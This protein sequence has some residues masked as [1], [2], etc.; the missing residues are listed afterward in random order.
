[1]YKLVR[2]IGSL[3]L[4]I[5]VGFTCKGK[6]NIPKDGSAII[7]SNHI[8]LFDPLSIGICTRR[9]IIFLAKKEL[10]SSK[11]SKWFFGSCHAIP[12]G[13][14][15]NDAYSLK[16]SLAVIKGNGLLGIFPEGTRERDAKAMQFKAGVGMLATKSQVPVIPVYISGSYKLNGKLKVIIGKAIDLKEYYGRKLTSQEYS[17]ISNEIVA[18][19]IFELKECI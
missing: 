10:F 2:A 13:R 14:D 18:K 15:G 8:H 9:V 6:D 16:K 3:Y 17:F 7:C 19:K 5:F 11:I 1:M 12:V 4:K